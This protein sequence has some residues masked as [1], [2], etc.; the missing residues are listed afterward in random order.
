ML[1]DTFFGVASISE[2]LNT[3]RT[4]GYIVLYVFILARRKCNLLVKLST[5]A[6]ESNINFSDG[7]LLWPM[8]QSLRSTTAHAVTKLLPLS[9]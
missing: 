6:L 2:N 4:I 8:L 7:S 5:D 3:G 1:Y 9:P